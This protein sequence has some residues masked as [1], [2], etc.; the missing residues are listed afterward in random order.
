MIAGYVTH[1]MRR[2][3]KGPVQGISLA[4]QEEERERRDNYI[5]KSSMFDRQIPNLDDVTMKML[6]GIGY[7]PTTGKRHNQ[8]K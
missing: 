7:T 2:I 3:Q 5:P 8:R 1:L 6:K 4:L